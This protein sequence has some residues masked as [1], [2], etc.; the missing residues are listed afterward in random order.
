MNSQYLVNNQTHRAESILHFKPIDTG[1]EVMI[2]YSPKRINGEWIRR[3]VNRVIRH[4]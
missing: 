3:Y 2:Q 1:Y 4:I